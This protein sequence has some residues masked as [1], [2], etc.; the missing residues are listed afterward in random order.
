MRIAAHVAC[1][2]GEGGKGVPGNT[3]R[4]RSDRGNGG[5]MGSW[6]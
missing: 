1:A 4:W 5:H 3:E 2:M 6:S